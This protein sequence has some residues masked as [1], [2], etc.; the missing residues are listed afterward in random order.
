MRI[1]CGDRWNSSQQRVRLPNVLQTALDEHSIERAG[2]LHCRGNRGTRT[3]SFILC[4]GHQGKRPSLSVVKSSAASFMLLASTPAARE[5][6]LAS[7]ASKDAHSRRAADLEGPEI[8][9]EVESALALLV[10]SVGLHCS[11]VEL[12]YQMETPVTVLSHQK[13]IFTPSVLPR[14]CS[15]KFT[16]FIAQTSKHLREHVGCWRRRGSLVNNNVYSR[17]FIPNHG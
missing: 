13:R 14:V 2:G 4:D 6:A 11:P 17:Q 16:S 12:V 3:A 5:R 9:Q 1:S 8:P 15:L 10:D 7:T